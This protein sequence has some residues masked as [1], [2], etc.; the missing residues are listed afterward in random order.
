MR[1]ARLL[2]ALDEQLQRDGGGGAPLRRQVRSQAVQVHE[3][4]TLVVGRAAPE[5][6][7][8][9]YGRLERR[10]VHS[11]SGSTGCTS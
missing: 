1:G 6:L 3:H 2:L 4:L 11:S 9:A 10:T 8:A 5:Q 7:V